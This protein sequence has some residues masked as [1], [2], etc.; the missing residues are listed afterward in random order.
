M[1]HRSELRPQR[2]LLNWNRYLWPRASRECLFIEVDQSRGRLLRRSFISQ[3]PYV[4]DIF[5]SR[6]RRF[7]E[8]VHDG[9]TEIGGHGANGSRSIQHTESVF[10]GQA[11]E[12]FQHPDLILDKTV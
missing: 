5:F 7:L 2:V 6:R 11:I 12:N 4:A 8:H 3:R 9:A 10:A 1:N